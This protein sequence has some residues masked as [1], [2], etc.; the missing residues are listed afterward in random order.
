MFYFAIESSFIFS[1]AGHRDCSAR[2][3]FNQFETEHSKIAVMDQDYLEARTGCLFP[4][5]Y[6]EYRVVST[7]LRN[8]NSFG[9]VVTYGSLSTTILREYFIY[10]F[11]SLVSDFGGTLGL[12]VGFSFVMLW[13]VVQFFITLG[14]QKMK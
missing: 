8:L 14:C 10:P 12:F 9:M 2:E 1:C 3:E 5:T 13:D 11:D 7:D 6:D 4:C